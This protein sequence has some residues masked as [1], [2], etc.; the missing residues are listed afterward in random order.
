MMNAR[1]MKIARM[2]RKYLFATVL[3]YILAQV[4]PH[5]VSQIN[6]SMGTFFGIWLA[7]LIAVTF[8]VAVSRCPRRGYY[9]H[10]NG[11]TLLVLRNCLHCQLHIYFDEIPN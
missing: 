2:R 7:L 1:V 10:V 6:S 5:N 8:L 3:L 11:V 9:F 4:V